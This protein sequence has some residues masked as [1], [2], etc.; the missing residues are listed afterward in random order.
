TEYISLKAALLSDL[1]E[2]YRYI[3]FAPS[4]KTLPSNNKVLQE[5]AVA[6]AK[7]SKKIA[8]TMIERKDFRDHIKKSVIKEVKKNSN[9]DIVKLSDTIIN[10]RFLKMSMDNILIGAPI[11][12]C[13]NKD[14]INDFKSGI[15]EQAYLTIRSDM[16]QIAKKYNTSFQKKT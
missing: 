14:K 7:K 13:A 1:C 9:P 10:E 11:I 3:G 15:L 5:N 2:F 8:A 4:N 16:V 12:E 6:D